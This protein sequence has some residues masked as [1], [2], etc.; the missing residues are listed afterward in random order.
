MLKIFPSEFDSCALNSRDCCFLR[1]LKTESPVL[2][3]RSRSATN[4][5]HIRIKECTSMPPPGIEP[6]SRS[7]QPLRISAT[8]RGQFNCYPRSEPLDFPL[9]GNIPKIFSTELFKTC[10][11]IPE[12]KLWA[13]WEPIFINLS[14]RPQNLIYHSVD[15]FL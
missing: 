12:L 9:H 5:V 1:C 2:Q 7:P 14:I 15:Y 6:G 10:P 4:P 8:P 11:F 13:F 3:G